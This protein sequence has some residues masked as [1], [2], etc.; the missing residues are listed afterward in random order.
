M[1]RLECF[2]AYDVRG[3]VPDELDEEL[4][5]L[6]GQAYAYLVRPRKVVVGHDVRLSSV[7]LKEALCSG[8]TACG[9]DVVD[10]GLVGTEEVYFATWS[11]GMDGGI[12]VTASH[13][14]KDYNGMKFTREGARPISADT[15][16]REMRE[17]VYRSLTERSGWSLEQ[18]CRERGARP[19]G[20]VT[21]LDNRPRYIEHLL[22]YVDPSR[23][24]PFK[25]VVNAG[26]GVAGPV[27]DLLEPHLPLKLV[28]LN[29]EPDGNFPKGVPN[30]LLPEN[31]TQTAEAVL[32]EGADLGL[33]WDGDFDRCFFFDERGVFIEGYYLVGLLAERALRRHPGGKIVHDP[34]LVWN[35]QE[36]VCNAGGTPVVSKSGHAF[37]KEKMREVDAVYA[38]E[39]SAHHYFK[40]F[41]YCDSGMIPWLLVVDAMSEEGRPLSALVEERVA[42]YPVS[43]E[44]NLKLADPASALLALRKK[45]EEEALFIDELDGLSVEFD[46]WRF[47]V[48]ASNT[49][50]VVRLN[51]ETRGDRK[52]LDEK[53]QEL[54]AVLKQEG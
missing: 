42:R 33:A 2:K 23:M 38:G 17:L 8:L 48:R 26:N 43:G 12:M 6:I 10:I 34:R 54:L 11:L 31:R 29:H 32:A 15:G 36:I 7:P 52:L 50:P 44:I 20:S 35:T 9:V 41:A 51:V 25:V 22:S 18:A 30:P 4:A 16:L 14:P 3:R 5:F 21:R 53:T 49:E 1:Q 24:R 40:E 28:K 47:N 39:M 13:N 46:R 19:R 37:M 27:L 45:Y